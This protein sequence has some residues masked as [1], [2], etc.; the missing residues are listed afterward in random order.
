MK[1]IL[2]VLLLMAT[3]FFA[4]AQKFSLGVFGGLSAYNGDLTEKAFPKKVTNGAI[5]ITGNYELFP[6]LTLRA[7][8]TYAVVG[9]ADR[10][11]DKPEQ[12]AR[13]LS[14]ETALYEFSAVGE[15]YFFDLERQFFSP[16]LMGGAAVYRFNPY[17]YS[18]NQKVYLKPLSTEGQGI[19]GYESSK[20]YSLTQLAL[21]FGGGVKFAITNN[22]RL[23]V[24]IGFRKLFTD[25]LDDVSGNYVDEA[26]LLAARGPLAVKMAY[27]GNELPGGDLYPA[28]GDQRG[29]P[30]ANDWYY[31]TGLHLTYRFGSEKAFNRRNRLGCP[32]VPL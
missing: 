29:S 2:S 16:Y 30:K 3:G 22:L 12:Q 8:F 25:H 27:R 28:K 1:C 14:F 4:Q 32:T 5:G 18:D 20:P 26:D 24:E 10:F 7:G 17:A 6:K 21:P 19:A 31:F 23:G 13:N 15:Y 11:S 9:G